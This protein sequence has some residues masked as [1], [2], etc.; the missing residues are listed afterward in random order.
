MLKI[1]SIALFILLTLQSCSFGSKPVKKQASFPA[2]VSNP[3]ND[4]SSKIY[5]TGSGFSP[6]EAKEAA[7]KDISGKLIT[8]ISSQSKSEISQFNDSVARSATQNI[9]TSTVATQLSNYKVV[10]STQIGDKL[11]IQLSISRS[12]FIKTTTSQLKELDDKI[13]STLRSASRKTKLQQLIASQNLR[14]TIDKARTLVRLLQAAG[15]TQNTDKYLAYYNDIIRKTNDLLYAVRFRVS[16]NAS[17]NGFAQHLVTLLHNKNISAS[18]GSK[19]RADA[20]IQISGNIKTSTAFSQHM[21]QLTVNI[22]ISDKNNRV[23]SVREYESS[24][25]STTD[26]N[27]ASSSAIK[28]MGAQFKNNGVL[29]SLGLLENSN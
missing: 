14:P 17:L 24:G 29:A 21:S 6:V 26:S 19:G 18:M 25:S 10:N 13:K 4:T 22:K 1:I 20:H 15:G 11:F 16:S 9:N 28:S 7:L 12:E 23:I 8:K 2:W 5:G 27:S 3:P